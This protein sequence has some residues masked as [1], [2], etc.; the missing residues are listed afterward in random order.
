MFADAGIS[1]V[2]SGEALDAVHEHAMTIL[3]EIGTDVRHEGALALLARAATAGPHISAVCQHIHAQ[4]SAHG[5]RQ[6]LGVLAL[7]KRHGTAVVEDAAKAAVDIGVLTYRFVRKY[8]ER[9]PPV[10]L[11]LRQVDPLIRQLTLYRDLIDRTT[12]DPQ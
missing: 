4:A 3:E 10:P 8:V 1:A 2:L 5:V 12:G 11:T 9:R 7:A 6:I